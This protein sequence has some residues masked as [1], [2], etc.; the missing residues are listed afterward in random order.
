MGNRP[1]QCPKTGKV[2]R[3]KQPGVQTM[4]RADIKVLVVDDEEM[5]CVNLSDYIED[6][7]FTVQSA[8]SGEEA[9]KLLGRQT[10][11]IAVVDMRL[12]GINGN[13]LIVKAHQ[14]QP[15]LRFII[16]TGS[17][18]YSLPVEIEAVGITLADLFMKPLDDLG[19]LT[20]AIRERFPECERGGGK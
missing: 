4:S 14:L 10:F 9:L 19:V 3:G 2:I 5:Y 16:H 20:K 6:D 15:H 12:P 18:S 11:D 7:G 17:T 1:A 13:T 8:G